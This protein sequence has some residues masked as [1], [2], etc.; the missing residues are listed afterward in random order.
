MGA[1]NRINGV[2]A[3]GN[4]R[5]IQ[6]VLRGRM[7]FDGYVVSDCGAIEDFHTGHKVTANAE[8]SAAMAVKSGCDLNCGEMYQFLLAAC[9]KGIVQE[10]AIDEAV[11]HVMM[12]RMRLGMFD[13]R[14]RVLTASITRKMIR[15]PITRWRGERRRSRLS[16]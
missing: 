8:E 16:C 9:R 2:P 7:E 3:S 15:K 10:S 5:L 11:R 13:A 12:T 6:E 1:Y 4:P 14:D